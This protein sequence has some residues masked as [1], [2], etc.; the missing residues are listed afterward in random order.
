MIKCEKASKKRADVEMQGSKEEILEEFSKITL[1]VY[2]FLRKTG[3]ISAV[4]KAFQ[5]A[6]EAAVNERLK[7]GTPPKKAPEGE[8]SLEKQIEAA[9]ARGF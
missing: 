8:N 6:V 2:V 1:A 5:E 7:G 3:V 4:E 9:M